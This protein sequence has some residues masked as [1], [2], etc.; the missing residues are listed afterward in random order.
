MHFSCFNDYGKCPVFG[1]SSKKIVI[2]IPG[3]GKVVSGQYIDGQCSTWHVIK[4]DPSISHP[5]IA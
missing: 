3:L 4:E 5:V 2:Q 1:C